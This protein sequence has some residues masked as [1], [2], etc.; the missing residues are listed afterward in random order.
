MFISNVSIFTNAET[1]EFVHV[2]VLRPGGKN[3]QRVRTHAGPRHVY[4]HSWQDERGRSNARLRRD[5]ARGVAGSGH[6]HVRGL[7]QLTSPKVR[8]REDGGGRRRLLNLRGSSGVFAKDSGEKTILKHKKN[9]RG[10][11]DSF[12][13]Q[14]GAVSS[15]TGLSAKT[16]YTA[17]KHS[18]PMCSASTKKIKECT[19][20]AKCEFV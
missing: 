9:P 8:H 11:F 1:A 12:T 5:N 18:Q 20:R 4:R 3:V 15:V 7:A 2:H 13:S 6:V 14:S 16:S 19:V 10:C 17:D